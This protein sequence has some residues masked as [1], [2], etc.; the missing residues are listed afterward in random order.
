M[1]SAAMKDWLLMQLAKD[2]Q[3][4]IAAGIEINFLEP[5]IANLSSL[6]NKTTFS[7]VQE[8]QYEPNRLAVSLALEATVLDIIQKFNQLPFDIQLHYKPLFDYL[9]ITLNS[10][11]SERSLKRITALAANL[12]PLFI[13]YGRYGRKM[14]SAWRELPAS[15]TNWQHLLWNAL[16]NRYSIWN[17]PY[18]KLE[19]FEVN[20]NWAAEEMQI[21]LF[22]LNYL[23]PL[24]HHFF[25]KIASHL[26]VNYYLFSPCKQFWS[27]LLSDKEGA[28]LK[29]YW[30]EQKISNSQQIALEDLLSDHHPLLANFGRLGRE[31]T[32]QIEMGDP[33]RYEHYPISDAYAAASDLLENPEHLDIE[34]E[35]SP[36]PLTLLEAVQ[37]D[38]LLMKNPNSAEKIAFD[39]Y[40]QT[41][42][43]HGA[44]KPMR[45]AQVVHDTIL[46]ILDTHR[47]DI[48]PITPADIVIMTP[49]PSLYAPFLRTVFE[50]SDSG[51]RLMMIETETIIHNSLIQGFL[52]LLQ[53]PFGRWDINALLH[54]M[55]YEEF[56]KKH[57]FSA[58]DVRTIATWVKESG[59]RW[60]ND[61]SH[62]NEL[63]KRNHC[64]SE[65]VEES[66]HGTWEHGLGMLLEGM[67]MGTSIDDG[68][69]SPL[70]G[71]ESSQRD[72]LGKFI[73]L[74]RSLLIDLNPLSDHTALSLTDWSSYL[75]C[76]IESY[77]A[78][79]EEKKNW[80]LLEIHLNSFKEATDKL[81]EVTFTFDSIHYHLKRSLQAE[82]ISRRDS[83]LQAV[84]FSS[85]LAMRAIPAKVVILMGM[86]DH[87]FPG[88]ETP[89]SM[90]LLSK[91]ALS[92]YYPSQVDLDR[93][94]FLE[95]LFSA[96]RY[97][98]TTYTSQ[99]AG[100]SENQPPSLLVKELLSHLD[101]A[102][103]FPQ[104]I[105]SQW[106]THLHPLIPFHKDYFTPGNST[107]A[108]S[109][110]SYS[111]RYYSASLVHYGSNKEEKKNFLPIIAAPQ[112]DENNKINENTTNESHSIAL[113]DLT[114]FVKN[115]LKTHCNKALNLYINNSSDRIYEENE[116]LLVSNMDRISFIKEA[117]FSGSSEK[118]TFSNAEKNGK[119]P[120]G[121]F[122]MLEMERLNGDIKQ[123]KNNLKDCGVNI[124]ALCAIE[125]NE[126]Y[127]EAK[128]YDS[129]WLLPPLTLKSKLFGTIKLT[130]R[131]DSVSTSGPILF[132]EGDIKESVKAWPM[133]LTFACL[134]NAY[135]L[136]IEPALVFGRGK[137]AERKKID[138]P[139]SEDL[140]I[141][142][143]EYYIKNK[144]N[145]SPLMP[146]WI[147]PILNGSSDSLQQLFEENNNKNE[148]KPVYDEYLKWLV[149]TSPT[150]DLNSIIEGWQGT[151]KELF[152]DM[153]QAWH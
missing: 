25:L 87:L 120:R 54:L 143:V 100:E 52:H 12:A 65:M 60:G 83:N 108:P 4:T 22:G 138:F 70:Q 147:D 32:L 96:R 133:A 9:G 47:H 5:T 43:I 130:G 80:K 53:L 15:K 126:R 89:Q 131:L 146:E 140:L 73:G 34:L 42:Q 92:D 45:E 101:D 141:R 72:L 145:L 62:R 1:P 38:I 40:D 136:P 28:K 8:Q 51:V 142:F 13:E 74:L 78:P 132:A 129:C 106:C 2:Q 55:E 44:P 121:P 85:L 102:Y 114:T 105:A 148:F 27:D 33:I 68:P 97:F 88:S 3:T 150:L 109:L 19:A 37:G 90:N 153:K 113:K 50:T 75:K 139:S 30:M 149:R 66:W 104:K 95:A 76:L 11:P 10:T 127:D 17:Y 20:D 63:L 35:E 152:M 122:R 69:F 91:S 117:I 21:H 24:Q 26:P 46:S 14:I 16:E 118:L 119:I 123:F 144:K 57:R 99:I 81:E 84:H 93:Y 135:G 110:K 61:H 7:T 41:I 77:F 71:V 98:I 56:Q 112:V 103:S 137:K 82:K 125:F 64:D 6:L 49:D 67:A 124:E 18:R 59:I 134:V 39:D 29:K 128:F 116:D 111:Q 48:D 94:I 151:A 107:S 115:P 23:P 36:H 86:S 79:D 58:E 31:M